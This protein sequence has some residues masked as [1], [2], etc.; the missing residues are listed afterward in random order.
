MMKILKK[1][2][3]VS[4]I[5]L[6]ILVLGIIVSH[7]LTTLAFVDF[8]AEYRDAA[9]IKV[10]DDFANGMNPYSIDYYNT[11]G[12]PPVVLDSSF[13][14][15]FPAVIFA[16][17]FQVSITYSVYFMNFIYF[18]LALLIM[19][20]IIFMI[21]KNISLSLF[22][23]IVEAICLRRH[24]LLVARPD[25]LATVFL[26]LILFLF[27]YYHL[28]DRFPWW[29]I[30]SIAIC[31]IMVF[32]LKIH[33]AM[34]GVA[35]FFFFIIFDRKQALR[36]M[37]F[38]VAFGCGFYILIDYFFPM[39]FSSWVV[40]IYEMLQGLESN[41]GGGESGLHY[42]FTKWYQIF[43]MFFPIMCLTL[44]GIVR[45]VLCFIRKIEANR[46][47]D[48]LVIN[49]IFN[50][51]ALC[52]LGQHR[53]ANLWY[54][55]F[56]LMP[57]VIIYAVMV[58]VSIDIKNRNW[59]INCIIALSLLLL[60]NQYK[61]ILPYRSY[62]G[63][64]HEE[65]YEIIR[66]HESPNMILS[67]HLA[68]YSMERDIYNYNYGDNCF[69]PSLHLENEVIHSIIPYTNQIREMYSL[70]AEQILEDIN[71]EKYSL[72]TTDSIDVPLA[73][74]GLSDEFQ[75]ALEN[76]YELHKELT[77]VLDVQNIQTWFWIPKNRDVVAK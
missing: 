14:N 39:H 19:Y 55:F 52:I 38:L 40:R 30:P 9:V 10:A 27:I 48:F 13:L 50:S 3:I 24:G 33:Y 32:Y 16:N 17:V 61:S 58:L 75:A 67:S 7:F 36:F 46:I 63:E 21:T 71:K 37:F 25:V 12:V 51:I 69:L 72:I 49:I 64:G 54:F 1:I 70:Q 68:L 62:G 31:C 28:C 47:E 22:A 73:E 4:N 76:H 66:E 2:N 34:I 8:P 60:M 41:N 29:F 45:R 56:M 18:I 5:V 23:V 77:T 59:V 57:S 74:F 44:F 6:L 15:V 42:V 11:M 35:L 65:A 26:L 53:G 20:F 43:K